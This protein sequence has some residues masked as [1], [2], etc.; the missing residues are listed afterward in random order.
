M[1]PG[2]LVSVINKTF[3]SSFSF[4]VL[5]LNTSE[6]NIKNYVEVRQLAQEVVGTFIAFKPIF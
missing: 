2:I 5:F 3:Q 1:I 4:A 6:M